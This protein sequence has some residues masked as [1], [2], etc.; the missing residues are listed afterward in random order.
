MK[1]RN[2]QLGAWKKRFAAINAYVSEHGGWMVSVP[3]DREMHFLAPPGSPLPGELRELGYIVERIG[4]TQ[5]ITAKKLLVEIVEV[6][7]LRVPPGAAAVA[8]I[9]GASKP[10]RTTPCGAR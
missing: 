6:F 9:P 5:R 10:Q 2:E 4:E 3:G 8:P 7:D 1:D